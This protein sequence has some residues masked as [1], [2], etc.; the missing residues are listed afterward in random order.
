MVE[1][2]SKKEVW[3]WSLYDFAN[4]AYASV[5]PILLFPL[6]Y[7]ALILGNSPNA[8]LWWG[9]TVGISVFLAGILSPVI[10]AWADVTKHRKTAFVLF[11]LLAIIGTAVLAITGKLAPLM[12]TLVFIITNTSFNIALT[13]YDSLMFN[14][15]NKDNSGRISGLGWALGN[16]GGMLCTLLVYP[17]LNGTNSDYMII[18]LMVSIFILIHKRSRTF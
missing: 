17:F 10:G 1:S 7:K 16:A 18:F 4:S 6:Y 13:L 11:S 15:S 3:S 12:V 8:D 2:P 5:I 9:L 14:V